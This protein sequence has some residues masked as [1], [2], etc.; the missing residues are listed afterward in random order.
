MRITNIKY[1]YM[2]WKGGIQETKWNMVSFYHTHHIFPPILS[3]LFYSLP[4]YVH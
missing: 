2:L 4:F 1:N 3:L